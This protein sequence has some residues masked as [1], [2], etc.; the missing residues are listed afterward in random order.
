M[1]DDE[2][3]CVIPGFVGSDDVV[4]N[5]WMFCKP[6]GFELCHRCCTDHRLTNNVQVGQSEFESINYAWGVSV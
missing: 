4:I 1:S 5:G 3:N 6:H 2:D